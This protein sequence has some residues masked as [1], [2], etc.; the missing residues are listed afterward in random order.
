MAWTDE[1]KARAI[2]MYAEGKP[3][4]DNSIELVNEIAQELEESVNGVRQ[5]LIQAKV[6]VKKD[7]AATTEK[8]KA[9]ATE[10][11]KRVSKESQIDALKKAIADKGGEIDDDILSKLTGKAAAYFTAV[12]SK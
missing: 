8:P 12:L 10:G 2:E 1:K 7:P 5:L 6:Y 3:T 4:K 11:T 9:G